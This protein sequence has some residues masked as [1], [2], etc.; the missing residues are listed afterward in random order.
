[1]P[2][3]KRNEVIK[4]FKVVINGNINK[5]YKCSSYVDALNYATAHI[6]DALEIDI[7]KD[8]EYF[9]CFLYY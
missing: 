2:I 6:K 9:E 4:M 3:G 5:A 8:N 7:Y 1:M